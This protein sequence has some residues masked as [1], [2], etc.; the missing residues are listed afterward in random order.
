MLCKQKNKQIE[1][2]VLFMSHH[3]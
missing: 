3:Q 2:Q 1:M